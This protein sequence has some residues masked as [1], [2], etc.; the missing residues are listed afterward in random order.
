MSAILYGDLI[1]K[2]LKIEIKYPRIG[3]FIQLRRKFL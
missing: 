3:K 1:I 2:Y